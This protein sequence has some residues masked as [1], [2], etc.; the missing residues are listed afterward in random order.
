[1]N[2]QLQIRRPSHA[3]SYTPGLIISCAGE[4]W[5]RAGAGYRR[6]QGNA[7]EVGFEYVL[8]G[9][10]ELDRGGVTTV[11]GAGEVFVFMTGSDTRYATGPS[12]ALHKRFATLNGTALMPLMRSMGLLGLMTFTPKLP[13][14]FLELLTAA[15]KILSEQGSADDMELSVIAWQL[16]QEAGRSY[17]HRIAEPVERML[18]YIGD[19]LH[20][21]ITLEAVADAVHMS[22]THLNRLAKRHL[23]TSVMEYCYTQRLLWARE[24]L[25][26]TSQ[27]IKEIALS[28]GFS[29]PLYFSSR[30]KQ[31]FGLAPSLFRRSQLGG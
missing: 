7:F 29:D 21:A 23:G 15:Q 24:M 19:H 8:S 26:N 20:E 10:A 22:P 12:G 16:L 28:S 2:E 13:Q 5:W 30:F 18:C 9:D 31:R 17:A 14:R 25:L 1:M 6:P 4:S 27:P 3:V 11:V